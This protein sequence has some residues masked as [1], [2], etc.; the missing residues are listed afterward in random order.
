M[1]KKVTF[2][3]LYS[4]LPDVEMYVG[5][6]P[7]VPGAIVQADSREEAEQE[8]RVVVEALLDEMEKEGFDLPEPRKYEVG[9][10]TIEMRAARAS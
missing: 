8:L 1:G 5:L 6:A 10:V 3:A 7:E 9:G 2:T 4:Y